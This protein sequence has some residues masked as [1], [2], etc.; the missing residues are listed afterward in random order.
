[1][2][3]MLGFY[4]DSAYIHNDETKKFRPFINLTRDQLAKEVAFIFMFCCYF[5]QV[6][7]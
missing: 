2:T 6:F 5:E 3:L 4:G 7:L 1:M